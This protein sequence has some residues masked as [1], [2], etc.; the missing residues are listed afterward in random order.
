MGS[1]EHIVGVAGPSNPSQPGMDPMQ[2]AASRS[3]R[4]RSLDALQRGRLIALADEIFGDP[5]AVHKELVPAR[6]AL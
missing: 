5:R 2:S 1:D 6:S 4:F 3:N